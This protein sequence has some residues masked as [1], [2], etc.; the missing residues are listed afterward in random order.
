MYEAGA[1]ELSD[2]GNQRLNY[3]RALATGL[4]VTDFLSFCEICEDPFD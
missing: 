1:E 3:D 2:V 4:G